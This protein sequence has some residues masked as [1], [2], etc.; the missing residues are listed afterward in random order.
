MTASSQQHP[1]LTVEFVSQQPVGT[2]Q[3]DARIL[4]R[5]AGYEGRTILR[6]RRYLA[7]ARPLRYRDLAQDGSALGPERETVTL[8]TDD[9]RLIECDVDLPPGVAAREY[10]LHWELDPDDHPAIGVRGEEMLLFRAYLLGRGEDCEGG[11]GG[12]EEVWQQRLIRIQWWPTEDMTESAFHRWCTSESTPPP[13]REALQQ[14]LRAEVQ[15][16]RV[17]EPCHARNDLD[18]LLAQDK[19]W[20]CSAEPELEEIRRLVV[21]RDLMGLSKNVF[22]G[23]LPTD[24]QH[25]DLTAQLATA[26]ERQNA[27]RIAYAPP[28]TPA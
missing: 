14:L 4:V 9:E 3:G 17:C 6:L 22:A 26:R 18:L 27:R 21:V 11:E 16:P 8:P 13:L 23:T 5:L 12:A 19:V 15:T 28:V 25:E 2:I 20:E 10:F 24:H 1:E 7:H